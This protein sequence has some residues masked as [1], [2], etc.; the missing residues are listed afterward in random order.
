MKFDDTTEQTACR[1]DAQDPLARFR[2]HFYIP[3]KT[4]YMDGNSLGLLSR[5]AEK[6]A[7]R[8]IREWKTLAIKG[9]LEG[10]VPWFHFAEKTG[11]AAAL[12][13][14]ADTS[15]VIMSTATTVNIHSLISSFY[16]PK[17]R[18]NKIIC[19]ALDFPSDIYALKAQIK[20]KGGH[21]EEDLILVPGTDAYVLDEKDI[22]KHIK[23]ETALIFL[24][25]V[26]YRSG[27]LLDMP[28]LTREAHARSIP[29]GFD[30]SHSAGVI[31]HYFDDWDIDFA[32]FCSYKYLNGGPGSPAFLYLNRR[33]FNREPALAGWFGSRKQAQFDMSTDFTPE[34][35][36]GGWQI[37]TPSLLS[38][39]PLEGSLEMIREAGIKPIREKSIKLT[40]YFLYLLDNRLAEPPYH[41]RTAT[42][43]SPGKRGGHI[44]LVH[45]DESWRISQALKARGVIPD[46][47]PPDIIRLAPSPLYNSFYEVWKTVQ[48]IRDIMDKK[49]YI[50]Y[51]KDRD[52][53]S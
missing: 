33:H 2:K 28:Y 12:L 49:E 53:V 50:H 51:S 42:P 17:G 9:W 22:I 23:T 35:S 46:F 31:P 52:T 18:R 20:L 47:R 36:A 15:E 38:A 27:Q 14:G 10:A 29:I 48:H 45:P 1:L 39:A 30:C 6:S 5:E 4:I 26:L 40:E 16:T 19:T 34:P 43:R 24:S 13:V 44:A 21:P 7:E 8:L 3:D 11:A 41:F 37:S 32:V 25:S